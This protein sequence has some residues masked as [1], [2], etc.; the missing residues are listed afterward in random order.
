VPHHDADGLSAGVGSPWEEPL[1][2]DPAVVADWGVR[3]PGRPA[4]VLY[5]RGHARATGGSL[6][7]EAFAEFERAVLA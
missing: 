2:E 4:E 6:V 7:P 5:G 3:P 1:G